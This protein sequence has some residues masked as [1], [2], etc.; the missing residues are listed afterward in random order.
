M[1]QTSAESKAVVTFEDIALFNNKVRLG[2]VIK[3][4]EKDREKKRMKDC[5]NELRY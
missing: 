4:T 2:L 5:N 1:F 3:K